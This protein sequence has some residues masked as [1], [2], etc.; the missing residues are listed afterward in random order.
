MRTLRR[1]LRELVILEW[2]ARRYVRRLHA[3]EL[4]PV[5]STVGICAAGIT[6]VVGLYSLAFGAA[7]EKLTERTSAQVD[8]ASTGAAIEATQA[9]VGSIAKGEAQPSA[10]RPRFAALQWARGL[11]FGLVMPASVPPDR[12]QKVVFQVGLV[13]IAFDGVV[14]RDLG[15]GALP[16]LLLVLYGLTL[17][18]CVHPMALLLRG[19][20]SLRRAVGLG[21]RHVA[22]GGL[23][24]CVAIVLSLLVLHATLSPSLTNLF[25]AVLVLSLTAFGTRA[26]VLSSAELYGLRKRAVSVAFLGALV[27]ST[28]VA[29][30]VLV[31]GLLVATRYHFLWD[32]LS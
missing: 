3:G 11:H 22:C 15:R 16:F 4:L 21:L 26:L 12:P 7:L 9:R 30:A 23:L 8:G 10:E 25:G 5:W 18:A 32:L 24:L 29:P 28:A 13:N 14:P 1:F 2:D 17:V 20:A 27:L 31:P 6:V 19:R